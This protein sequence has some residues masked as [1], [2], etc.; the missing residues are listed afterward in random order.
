[1]ELVLK[2]IVQGAFIA[3][4]ILIKIL[5]LGGNEKPAFFAC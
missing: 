5:K 2:N 3:K 1:M 4:V